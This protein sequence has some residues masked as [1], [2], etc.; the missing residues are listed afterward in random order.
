MKMPR[1][2]QGGGRLVFKS[3]LLVGLAPALLLVGEAYAQSGQG[4]GNM[5]GMSGSSGAGK[6]QVSSASATGT[7]T[8]VNPP[9]RKITLN[10]EPIPAINW[11]AMTMEFPAAA[12]VDLSKVSPGA[13]VRFTLSGSTGS[14][15]VESVSPAE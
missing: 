7:V 10:H 8:A 9:Q 13:K 14:Y 12:S 5:P 4:T 2:N 6:T 1:P 3:A 11:P 15:T